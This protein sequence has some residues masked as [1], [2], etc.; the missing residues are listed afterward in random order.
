MRFEREFT[1][2]VEGDSR[3]GRSPEPQI[4]AHARQR[5]PVAQIPTLHPRRDTHTALPSSCARAPLGD[6]ACVGEEKEGASEDEKEDCH[7]H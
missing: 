6:A 3:R 4:P 7:S 1:G 5:S 2:K